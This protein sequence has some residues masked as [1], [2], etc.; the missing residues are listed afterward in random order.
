MGLALNSS[1]K[2]DLPL[3]TETIGKQIY[4]SVTFVKWK[5]Y[6][7]LRGLEEES[8]IWNILA[9]RKRN[10]YKEKTKEDRRE[11]LGGYVVKNVEKEV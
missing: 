11:M 9:L 7:N 3:N 5:R 10:I 4:M 2:F 1:P 6:Q 8:V